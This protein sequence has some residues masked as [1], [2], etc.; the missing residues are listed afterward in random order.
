MNQRDITSG[1]TRAIQRVV[2]AGGAVSAVICFLALFFSGC[3]V[4]PKYVR[5][6]VPVSPWYKENQP[7]SAL[8]Q[9]GGWKQ[10]SPRDAMLRG[11]W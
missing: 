1:A 2:R 9:A 8:A 6:P 10:A 3:T 11:K 7:G 5:P 4:G